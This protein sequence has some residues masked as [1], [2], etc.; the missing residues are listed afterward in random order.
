MDK[1]ELS[2]EDYMK[3]IT[4]NNKIP[5][6]FIVDPAKHDEDYQPDILP[7]RDYSNTDK[8]LTNEPFRANN[9]LQLIDEMNQLAQNYTTETLIDQ[10][11]VTKVIST[12]FADLYDGIDRHKIYLAKNIQF[13]EELIQVN[14]NIAELL[15]KGTFQDYL[16]NEFSNNLENIYYT[17]NIFKLTATSKS[18]DNTAILNCLWADVDEDDLTA[19]ELEERIAEKGLP[20]PSFIINSGHGYHIIWKLRPFIILGKNYKISFLK[21]W[22]R[23]IEYISNDLSA[24]SNATSEEKYLRLPFTVNNKR[25]G[26]DVCMSSIVKYQPHNSYN[27]TD[28]YLKKELEWKKYWKDIYSIN[29][30][31]EKSKT[32]EK[33]SK[34]TANNTQEWSLTINRVK[35]LLEWLKMRDFNIEGKRN[36]FLRIMQQGYQNIYEINK[37]LKPALEDYELDSIVK[38]YENQRKKGNYYIMPAKDKI[39]SMLGITNEEAEQLNTF[40]SEEYYINVKFE[41]YFKT[42][43][44]C[45]IKLAKYQYIKKY[46]GQNKNLIGIIGDSKQALSQL[47]R[48][49]TKENIEKELKRFDLNYEKLENLMLEMNQRKQL[50][51]M[52]KEKQ[53]LEDGLN[54]KELLTL[55][56]KYNNIRTKIET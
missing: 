6:K 7:K 13:K 48:K 40:K 30:K 43:K 31:N 19:E 22:K 2:H 21:K 12:F 55:I 45:L 24:D 5:D 53:L 23:I 16:K 49:A 47:K 17:P 11:K 46:R 56:N 14:I 32:E 36:V 15:K 35:A 25:N 4:G 34:K 33:T 44:N 9:I 29:G 26:K 52:S 41:K 38:N 27:I 20:E 37:L 42:I 18:K 8:I 1:G 3:I 51:E 10:K 39:I 28:F 50:T 54:Q